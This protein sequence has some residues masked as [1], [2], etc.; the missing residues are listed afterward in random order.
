MMYCT[1]YALNLDYVL[2]TSTIPKVR[3]TG[4]AL[5]R[6]VLLTDQ[7]YVSST[8]TVTHGIIYIENI[9]RYDDYQIPKAPLVSHRQIENIACYDDYHQNRHAHGNYSC[10]SMHPGII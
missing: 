7:K 5:A 3:S 2:Y 1:H 9:A 4:N 6:S 10:L 8:K